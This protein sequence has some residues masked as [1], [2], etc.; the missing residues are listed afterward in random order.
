MRTLLAT[1]L[2]L[3]LVIAV[4]ACQATPT[5]VTPGLGIAAPDGVSLATWWL[6]PDGPPLTPESTEVAILLRERDCASGK[7]PE[8]RVLAPTIVV[9]PDAFE[10]AV[11]IRQQ[12][13][14]QECPGNPSYSTSI[15]LPEPIGARA[16]FDASAF[17]PREVTA[18]D[19]G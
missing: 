16:L 7:P 17:P 5:P 15:M 2:G 12:H 6:D 4:T 1:M 13:T 10:I 11:G 19:P 18:E 8:G 3:V 14:A 9:T